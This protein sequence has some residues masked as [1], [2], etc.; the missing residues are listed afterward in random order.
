MLWRRERL[1]LIRHGTN[2]QCGRSRAKVYWVQQ[3]RVLARMA[4]ISGA[5]AEGSRAGVHLRP[6]LHRVRLAV[7]SKGAGP[8]QA[9]VLLLR[10]RGAHPGWLVPGGLQLLYCG[11]LRR[12]PA[13]LWPPTPVLRP[14]ALCGK[15]A[16]VRRPPAAL[17]AATQGLQAAA[18]I[19][20]R[21]LNLQ[22]QGPRPSIEGPATTQAG[23]MF[24]L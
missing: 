4:T 18:G 19:L 13:W 22:L 2:A 24:P 5:C 16:Q 17:L 12:Q 1:R 9:A 6:T 7:S 23:T 21:L 15:G 8:P 11:S 10:K 20:V 14:D 3:A